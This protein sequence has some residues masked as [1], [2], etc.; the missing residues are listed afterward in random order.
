MKQILFDI[1]QLNCIQKLN[2]R[3]VNQAN[4]INKEN[5]NISESLK[6]VKKFQNPINEKLIKF[7]DLIK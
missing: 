1:D 6:N 3:I 4:V 7:I 2:L 5:F